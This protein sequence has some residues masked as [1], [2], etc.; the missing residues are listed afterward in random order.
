MDYEDNYINIQH[1][2]Y[3][4]RDTR[5]ILQEDD[6][7][8]LDPLPSS[9]YKHEI[10]II[11]LSSPEETFQRI[12]RHVQKSARDM[13]SVI[14]HRISKYSHVE[15]ELQ[16]TIISDCDCKGR[17]P[18]DIRCPLIRRVRDDILD[19]AFRRIFERHG[20]LQ[21]LRPFP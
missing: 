6:R 14:L 10:D 21:C 17:I 5:V 15:Y 11:S 20:D 19:Q 2:F 13:C 1:D 9:S 7:M 3:H 16:R 4:W 18:L 8:Q 12:L